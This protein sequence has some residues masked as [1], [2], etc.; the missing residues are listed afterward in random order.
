MKLDVKDN[1]IFTPVSKG[2][3]MEKE[4]IESIKRFIAS[5]EQGESLQSKSFFAEGYRKAI[6]DIKSLIEFS[7]EVNKCTTTPQN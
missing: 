7:E 1:G 6:S 3:T 2:E 5:M 4:L